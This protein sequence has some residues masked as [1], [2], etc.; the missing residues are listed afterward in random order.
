MW[1]ATT[2]HGY[3]YLIKGTVLNRTCRFVNKGPHLQLR[4]QFLQITILFNNNILSPVLGNSKI[5]IQPNLFIY[6]SYQIYLYIYPTKSIYLSILPNLFIYL[7]YL[8]YLSIYPTNLIYLS[9][10]FNQVTPFSY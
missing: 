10:L 9:F 3:S 8:I 1:V 5:F 4:S 7:S 6:L 2:K